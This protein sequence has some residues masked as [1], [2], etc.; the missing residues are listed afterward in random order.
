MKAHSWRT[1]LEWELLW[2]TDSSLLLYYILQFWCQILIWSYILRK[3]YI[4][5]TKFLIKDLQNQW[6]ALL[7]YQWFC[8]I[9]VKNFVKII[10]LYLEYNFNELFDI[11]YCRT[12]YKSGESLVLMSSHA[13][14]VIMFTKALCIRATPTQH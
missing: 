5:L 13:K 8:K 7:L 14:V 1:T 12:Q 6:F 4:I 2:T 11:E 10:F 9:D 3:K